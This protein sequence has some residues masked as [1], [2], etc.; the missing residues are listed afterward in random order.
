MSSIKCAGERFFG[1]LLHTFD[2]S[3]LL[4]IPTYFST[5]KNKDSLPDAMPFFSVKTSELR[6]I[7]KFWLLTG[8]GPQIFI[9]S[10]PS[11]LYTGRFDLRLNFL[12]TF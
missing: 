4:L 7:V 10:A 12:S 3:L 11:L 1:L 6:C 5:E 9:A 8:S 2:S